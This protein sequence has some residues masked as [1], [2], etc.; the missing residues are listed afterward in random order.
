MHTHTRSR[1]FAKTMQA[2]DRKNKMDLN[3][4]QL[5][6]NTKLTEGQAIPLAKV[7][8]IWDPK[9]PYSMLNIDRC[10]RGLCCLLC[11]KGSNRS[12][13]TPS[14]RRLVLPCH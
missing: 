14:S 2:M 4:L 12:V 9:D 3:L 10:V 7:K 1:A 13:E 8:R 11:P 5:C 6:I